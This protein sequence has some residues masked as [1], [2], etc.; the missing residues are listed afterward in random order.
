LDPNEESGS[1]SDDYEF[2]RPKFGRSTSEMSQ[3]MHDVCKRGRGKRE[4]RGE[5]ENE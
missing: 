1:S 5:E 4:K 2:S 3:T